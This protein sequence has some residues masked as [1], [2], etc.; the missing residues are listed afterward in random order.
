M[1]TYT[2]QDVADKQGV[3]YPTAQRHVKKLTKQRKFKKTSVGKC[4]NDRDWK[5][6]SQLLGF[7]LKNN[8]NANNTSNR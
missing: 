2:L 7:D 6:L 3:S 4:F 5:K 1:P 8:S